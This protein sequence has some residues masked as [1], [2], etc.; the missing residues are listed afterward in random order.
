MR[1]YEKPLITQ[2]DLA[3]SI[4]L[5]VSGSTAEECDE[6][7]LTGEE[8]RTGDFAEETTSRT[9]LEVEKEAAFVLATGLGELGDTFSLYGFT[10]NGRRNCVFYTFKE[11][12]EDWSE[13]TLQHLMGAAP[14]SA[15][16]I[17]AA[18]RHAGSKLSER[19]QKTRL[20]MLIT[21]GK[22]CDQGY[23][24]ESHYAQHDIH[25][26]C[27]ENRREGIHTFCVTTTDNPPSDMELMFP[28]GR[29]LI[30]KDIR[31]LPEVL[32]RLYLRLTH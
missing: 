13:D 28:G 12:D 1:F 26:A 30:L 32:S 29:Y 27:Q 10:G 2:R 25:T 17:G 16:R 18:L 24:T 15:T 11:F 23:D 19:P 8:P 14:G 5:D 20:L 7:P 31:R 21:D 9:V 3:V 22:P 4:L 6:S